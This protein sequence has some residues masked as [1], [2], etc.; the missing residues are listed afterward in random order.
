MKTKKNKTNK[1]A[2][3]KN[4]AKMRLGKKFDETFKNW[5]IKKKLMFS[6]I[7]IIAS[8][9]VL[10]VLLLLG[11]NAIKSTIVKMYEGPTTSAFCVGDIRWSIVEM[12]RTVNW[13]IAQGE[14]NLETNLPTMETELTAAGDLMTESIAELKEILISEKS[15]K[16]LNALEFS[17]TESLK[18][19]DRVLTL[20][21]SGE[22][23]AANTY[24][25]QMY[26]PYVDIV[27]DMAV[28]L[29]ESIFE[30]GEEYK[31]SA[32]TTAYVLMAI[33]FVLLICVIGF[34]LV[35]VKKVTKAIVPPIKQVEAAS[36]RLF[37][38]DMSA[39]K[40]LTYQSNDEVGVLAEALRG[41]MD[42][43]DGWV[44]EISGTLSEIANGDLTKKPEDITDFKGDF[45]TI[46][47]SFVLIL[48][49][50]NEALSMIAQSAHEVD[51][52]SDEIAK[53]ATDLAEG[54]TEQAGAVEELTAT[55]ST[56]AAAAE[57]SAKQTG[58]AYDMIMKSVQNAEA[59]MK[60]VHLLQEE[61]QKIKDISEEVQ[62]IIGTIEDIASQTSLLSLNASI[63]AA[64]A[65]EAGRGFAVVADQIGKLAQDSAQAAVSTRNLIGATV[66]EVDNG[67][68]ITKTTVEAFE[69]I[70]KDLNAFADVTE[71]VR[72]GSLGAAEAMK[73]VESGIDQ[74]SEV[75]QQNAAASEESSAVSEELAAKAEELASQVRRFKLLDEEIF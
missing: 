33:G 31:N 74:I 55:V 34:A 62:S 1:V 42:A 41:S 51:I 24:N 37:D 73:E 75:T 29:D 70:I 50:L 40:D 67:N 59:D 60:Q 49:N 72:T 48:Q 10:I 7:S 2:K 63:E 52:G 58:E 38:G 28:A 20:L 14:V 23:A 69:K 13:L 36:K 45:V 12:Q 39:S 25:D 5:S 26:K 16:A 19:Q 4:T 43:L 57:D 35:L 9:V 3:T 22:F 65:G 53:S 8:T 47:E 61:M 46:K 17:M 44:Q 32:I 56:V 18:H 71:T 27:R 54:T 21:K 68:A 64:R 15:L 11:M 66:E 6:H 30:A